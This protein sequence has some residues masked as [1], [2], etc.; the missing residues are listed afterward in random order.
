MLKHIIT[1]GL[2]GVTAFTIM[3]TWIQSV[4]PEAWPASLMFGLFAAMSSVDL[5]DAWR[6]REWGRGQQEKATETEE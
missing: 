3:T 1:S 5:L 6:R 4:A 2:V